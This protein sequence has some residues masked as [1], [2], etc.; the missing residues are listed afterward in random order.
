V[1]EVKK[2][3]RQRKLSHL[4]PGLAVIAVIA[5][6]TS[7]GWAADKEKALYSFHYAGEGCGS[8]GCVPYAG[9]IF[10]GSGN[11]YGTTSYGG[12]GNCDCGT[13]FELSPNGGGG[14]T[15]TVLYSFTGGSDGQNPSQGLVFDNAGNLFGVTPYGGSQN[16]GNG[17]GVVFELQHLS[18]GWSYSTIYSFTG[19]PDGAIPDAGLIFDGKGNLYG[20]TA[21]G[22]VNTHGSLGTVFELTP[23][24]NGNWTESVIYSFGTRRGNG[25]SPNG[26]IFDGVG[27]LYGTTQAGG[28]CNSNETGCGI[29]FQLKPVSGAWKESILYSF[30]GGIDGEVPTAGLA[31]DKAGHL[32]GTTSAGGDY[33]QGTVF[34]VAHS[35]H[36]WSETVLHS[37]G[38]SD[39]ALP[40][41]GLI[42]DKAGNLYGTSY[43]GGAFA[44][45]AVYELKRLK[46]GWTENVLYSFTGGNDGN[47]PVAG[48]I[49]DAKANLYGTTLYGGSGDNGGV[50]FEIMR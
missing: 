40:Y 6:L 20:T 18:G 21:D 43:R 22:G 50:A 49:F 17:C 35:K 39:G 47:G 28:Q 31:L 14:W 7:I 44:S 9:L 11:L 24:D 12:A 5:A 4:G 46:S 42:L 3:M 38:G 19:N 45:G 2:S 25:A 30:K 16:C 33:E 29:V 23:N 36:G 34:E 37:F 10:D 27:S 8:D 13:V 15:E 48:L 26:L 32:Y 1:F 41:A